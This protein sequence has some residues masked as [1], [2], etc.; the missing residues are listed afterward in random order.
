MSFFKEAL[1]K[2]LQHE[3][4]Y[5]NDPHDNGGETY[6]GISRKYHKEWGGWVIIDSYK[7][8]DLAKIEFNNALESDLELNEKVQ[9]FYYSNFWKKNKLDEIENQNV[10]E[11]IFDFIVNSGRAI[12]IIQKALNL[13]EDG[14]IGPNTIKAINDKDNAL[15][16]LVNARVEYLK[17]LK[18]FDIYGRGWVTRANSY[19]V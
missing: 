18:G 12:K 14:I 3:G 4:G 5:S 10:A 15:Q 19:L 9:D 7:K 2:T 8:Q 11:F 13:V 6:R 17:G 16:V 1:R